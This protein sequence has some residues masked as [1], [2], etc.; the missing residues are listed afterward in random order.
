MSWTFEEFR[1]KAEGKK[2]Q[3]KE[4]GISEEDIGKLRKA[5]Q[6]IEEVCQSTKNA[7]LIEVLCELNSWLIYSRGK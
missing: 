4:S 3:I 7:R 6:L 2:N 1:Q 5:K